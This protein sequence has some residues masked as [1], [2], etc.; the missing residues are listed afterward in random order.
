MAR[1]GSR[2]PVT[3]KAQHEPHAASF[4]ILLRTPLFL[5]SISPFVTGSVEGIY[6]LTFFLGLKVAP[7]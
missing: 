3:E 2:D 1:A 4:L 5:Q 7:R 6:E